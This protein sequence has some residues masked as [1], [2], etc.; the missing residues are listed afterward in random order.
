MPSKSTR[1]NKSKFQPLAANSIEFQIMPHKIKILPKSIPQFNFL[2]FCA[3]PSAKILNYKILVFKIILT[4]PA[5]AA[6]PMGSHRTLPQAD[7][8]ESSK[9]QTATSAS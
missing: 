4:N 8:S 5:A 7:I 2:K 1:I 3:N 6:K 9:A